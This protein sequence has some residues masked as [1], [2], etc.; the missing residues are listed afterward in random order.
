[1]DQKRTLWITIAVGLFL[2]VVIGA[3]LF[4]HAPTAKKESKTVKLDSGSTYTQPNTTPTVPTDAFSQGTAGAS[5]TSA[6]TQS[7][8]NAKADSLTTDNLTVIA[9]GTTNVIGLGDT[10]TADTTASGTTTIDLN[11]LKTTPTSGTVT[12]QNKAAE[13]AMAETAAATTPITQPAVEEKVTKSAP[14]KKETP[15][16]KATSSTTTKKTVAKTATAPAKKIAD[17]FWVQAASYSTKKNADEARNTLDANKIPCEVFTYKDTKGNLFYRV[18]VGPYTTKSEAEYW[19]E[20]IA[21]IDLFTKSG[22]YI[23]NSSAPKK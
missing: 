2:L 16:K 6:T 10:S 22:S 11:T 21:A 12:A 5:N 9:N 4:F 20:R 18:R 23:T 15:A 7:D 17:S 19:K 14:A 8:E 3:A 13:N 1:M